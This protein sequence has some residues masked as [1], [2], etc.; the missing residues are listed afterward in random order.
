MGKVDR[1]GNKVEP[2]S[3]LFWALSIVLAK[4][5]PARRPGITPPPYTKHVLIWS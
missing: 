5:D 3:A 2:F 4:P 1:L